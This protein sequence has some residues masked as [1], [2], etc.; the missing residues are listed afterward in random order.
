[1][2]TFKE[3]LE[4]QS[5]SEELNESKFLSKSFALIQFS[6]FRSDTSKLKSR[7][8]TLKRIASNIQREDEVSDKL[9]QIAEGFEA[10][11]AIF[12]LESSQR[13]RLMNTLLADI[14]L[15]QDIVKQLKRKKRR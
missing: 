7:L 4:S 2:K 3:F 15:S 14:L 6:G 5:E 12:D 13:N 11:A 8:N 1:M 10:L 9:D